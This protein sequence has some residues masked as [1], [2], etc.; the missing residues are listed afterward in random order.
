MAEKGFTFD[1]GSFDTKIRLGSS[2]RSR[3]LMGETLKNN[4]LD[5]IRD[6]AIRLFPRQ[7][8]RLEYLVER[9]RELA[10]AILR[11][12]GKALFF[13]A[14]KYPMAIPHFRRDPR[15]D[16]RVVHLV[17]DVRGASLSRVRNRGETSWPAAVH[18]WLRMNRSID[19]QLR[20]LST[21]NWIRIRY[22]D[23]CR[24]PG[25]TL[26]RFFRFCHLA[27]HQLPQDFASQEHHIVG[28]RMRMKNAGEIRL[29]ETWRRTLTE[30]ELAYT[31]R[32]A[33]TLHARYGYPPMSVAD[34]P[35]SAP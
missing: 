20:R 34:L 10:G 28:N 6:G 11:V 25:E 31:D 14:S 12:S 3:R 9:N 32:F 26:D 29:D 5:D 27:P 13:D 35:R 33:G 30:S 21:D 22:E 1:P 19:R 4:L 7:R 17:R 2:R 8:R 18:A 24:T 23:L 16:L 15:I